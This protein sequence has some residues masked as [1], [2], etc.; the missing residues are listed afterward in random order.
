MNNREAADILVFYPGAGADATRLADG[1]VRQ[2]TCLSLGWS[3]WLL[4]RFGF[5]PFVNTSL[6]L[7]CFLFL[8][9]LRE[10]SSE[11]DPIFV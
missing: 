2:I 4:F 3:V 11:L 7:S 1:L 10:N 5:L 6:F 8:I 9:G